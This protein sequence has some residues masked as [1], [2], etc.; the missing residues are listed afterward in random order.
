MA[1]RLAASFQGE[2]P[3]SASV[4]RA[5]R[6]VSSRRSASVKPLYTKP[7]V[8]PPLGPRSLCLEEEKLI[9]VCQRKW[10]RERRRKEERGRRK[11]EDWKRRR[12]IWTHT[13]HTIH[14]H[15]QYPHSPCWITLSKWILWLSVN[16][17]NQT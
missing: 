4:G 8:E 16:R 13:T 17:L 7:P 1:E 5:C 14:T 12:K 10:K 9:I 11:E 3:L 6:L 15:T 2:L